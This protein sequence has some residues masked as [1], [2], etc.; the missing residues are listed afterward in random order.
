MRLC[1]V[2]IAALVAPSTAFD[3]NVIAGAFWS[4][5]DVAKPVFEDSFDSR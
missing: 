5:Q 3:P 1:T 2:K 4:M